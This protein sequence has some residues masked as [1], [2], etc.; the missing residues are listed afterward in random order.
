[1][2]FKNAIKKIAALGTGVTMLGATLM[3][4]MAADLADYPNMFM[5]DD[6]FNAVVVVGD[7]ALPI[8]IVG[9]IDMAFS[10][11]YE[12]TE[13]QEISIEGDTTVSASAGVEVAS[14]GDHLTLME[15]LSGVET[16]FKEDDMTTLLADG[17]VTDDSESDDYD[18][19][20][21]LEL[22]ADT[23]LFDLPDDEIFGTNPALY[24]DHT[25]DEA[26][27][28][29]VTID[30]IN[31]TLLD[32][33]ESITMLGRTFTFD[34]DMAFGD[35]AIVLYASEKTDTIG[36]GPENAKSVELD[37][38]TK[39]DLEVIGANTDGSTATLRVNGKSYTV[40]SGDTVNTAGTSLY[41]N[42]VFTYNVP[43]PGATVE[44]FVG[45]DK[46]E[47]TTGG[48]WEEIEVDGDTLSGYEAKITGAIGAVTKMEFRVTPSDI[49][50]EDDQFEYLLVGESLVDP[51]FKTLKMEFAGPTP[52]LM[53]EEKTPITFDRK[54]DDLVLNF[55]NR[56]DEA[57]ELALFSQG[58][59]DV[60]RHEKW[61]GETLNV[62]RSIPYFILQEGDSA[63]FVTKIFKLKSVTTDEVKIV[64]LTDNTEKTYD[65]AGEEI[66]STGINI[67]DW[68]AGT[69]TILLDDNTSLQ[70]WTQYDGLL[71][72]TADPDN[73]SN[74]DVVFTDDEIEKQNV[75]VRK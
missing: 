49:D 10:L 4:A 17:V 71:T 39:L 47:L 59:D 23:V 61:A 62:S 75:Y 42:D 3:G 16:S 68:D 40:E 64:D 36:L 19:T 9:A 22:S 14:T 29:D 15:A 38:G 12:A 74:D 24:L 25:T 20:Q 65:V 26:Y 63:P 52:G 18:Y 28:L 30:T 41:I 44:Y 60:D 67:S 7:N 69:D 72:F 66:G 54:G 50:A 37:D 11:Q 8:D 43:A 45:S 33:S 48:A 55:V 1:M 53:S 73:E 57:Y 13:D 58:T 21:E 51:F 6:K 2:K 5:K 27:V 70:V 46:V 32:D 35:T 31:L 56:D 34:P